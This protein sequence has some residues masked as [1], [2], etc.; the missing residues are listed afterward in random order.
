MI[1]DEQNRR[2]QLTPTAKLVTTILA[3]VILIWVFKRAFNNV[4]PSMTKQRFAKITWVQALSLLFVSS[5][6]LN[7]RD[8]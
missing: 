6:L 4:I 8:N 3:L 5:M 2:T 1:S 7:C